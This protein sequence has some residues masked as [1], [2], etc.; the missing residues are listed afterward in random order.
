MGML[1]KEDMCH[2]RDITSD[3]IA[4]EHQQTCGFTVICLNFF[5]SMLSE[6]IQASTAMAKDSV[7]HGKAPMEEPDMHIF[8]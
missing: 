3:I 2:R 1:R 4:S 5:T 8:E 7:R 6:R